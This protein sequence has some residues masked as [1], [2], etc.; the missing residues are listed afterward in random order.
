[1]KHPLSLL[2]TVAVL[3]MSGI[4]CTKQVEIDPAE[5]ARANMIVDPVDAK[6]LGYSLRWTSDI[7]GTEGNHITRLVVQGDQILAVDGRLNV[8]SAIS[9]RDGSNIWLYPMSDRSSTLYDPIRDGNTVMIN[10]ETQVFTF[11]AETGALINI[12][13]LENS[14]S[15]APY[16]FKGL[17]IF[18]GMNGKL[19][20]H[21]VKEGFRTWAY[22][23]STGIIVRPI[24]MGNQVFAADV[25]GRW[26]MYDAATGTR[27][28]AGRA[29]GR[30]SAQPV[31]T[32]DAVYVASE[33]QALYSLDRFTGDDRVGWPYRTDRPLKQGVT[34][35]G[36]SIYLPLGA[37]ALICID[38]LTGRETWRRSG[39]AQPILIT[40]DNY[41]LLNT[42]RA[43]V[44]ADNASG[45]TVLQLPCKP[46]QTVLQGPEGSL[47]LLAKDGK[48]QRY[49]PIKSTR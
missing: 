27:I 49:D 8:L 21:S 48:L 31:V 1:M 47:I 44:L 16:F 6:R 39:Q 34:V 42:T 13:S 2:L 40:K 3:L 24:G 11:N 46:L 38:P 12:S 17:A 23:M 10:S 33:D 18:G 4:A 20:A 35:I 26:A 41:V 43:L 5:A 29:F 15:T 25:S 9:T 14:V 37:D 28:W 30:I 36:P 22:M 45:K 7:S 19:F 32:K